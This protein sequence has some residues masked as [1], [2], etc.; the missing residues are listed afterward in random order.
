MLSSRGDSP[1]RAALVGLAGLFLFSTAVLG[2]DPGKTREE[3]ATERLALAQEPATAPP[4]ALTPR[5]K[6]EVRGDIFM[7]KKMYTDAIAIYQGIL[8]TEPRNATL[9]NKV[10]IA[11]HQLMNLGQ[12][13]RYYDRAIKAD[14]NHA[15]AINNLGMVHYNRKKYKQAA[16]QFDKSLRL[17]PELPA[18]A[19]NLGHAYFQMKKYDEALIAFHRA[20]ELDPLV[21]ER[22]SGAA[23]SLLQDRSVEDRGFY[24]FFLAKSFAMQGDAERCAGYLRKA[25][26]ESFKG[27]TGVAKDPAFAKVINDPLVQEIVQQIEA[28]AAAARTARP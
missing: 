1:R 16:Q 7:A 11:Y 3:R 18:V 27:L 10:G 2:Q 28:A 12:A 9:L 21:F 25:R 4:P 19:S 26:D 15:F 24:F 23:G 20:L 17:K 22:R 8:R 6:E 13:K 14:K 5:E